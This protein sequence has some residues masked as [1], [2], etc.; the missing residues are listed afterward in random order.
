MH[1]EDRGPGGVR[2]F[3]PGIRYGLPPDQPATEAILAVLDDVSAENLS[4]SEVTL[5][6]RVDPD[7][8]DTL[9]V[10]STTA[11]VTFTFAGCEVTVYGDRSVMIDRLE[12]VDA[13]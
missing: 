12:P 13:G 1:S 6:D 11:E 2:T 8:L 3:E 4:A 7:A 5:S 10:S 9:F